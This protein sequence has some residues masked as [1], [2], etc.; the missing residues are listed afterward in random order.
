MLGRLAQPLIELLARRR[1]DVSYAE[2]DEPIGGRVEDL[3]V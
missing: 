3:P 1:V 2:V